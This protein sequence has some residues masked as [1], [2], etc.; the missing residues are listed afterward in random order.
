MTSL[1]VTLRM[2]NHSVGVFIIQNRTNVYCH[3]NSVTV[4]KRPASLLYVRTCKIN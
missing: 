3:Y 1:T 4:K 2:V